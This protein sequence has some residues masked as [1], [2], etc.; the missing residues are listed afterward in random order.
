[1]S[2]RSDIK[3]IEKEILQCAADPQIE[4]ADDGNHHHRAWER[5]TAKYSDDQERNQLIAVGVALTDD[6]M[7][8]APL[9]LTRGPTLMKPKGAERLYQLEHPVWHWLSQQSHVVVAAVLASIVGA[10]V[11]S[12]FTLLVDGFIN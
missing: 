3:T 8:V 7:I 2:K 10:I 9:N 12:G 11:G 5:L 4:L 6:E 1:M